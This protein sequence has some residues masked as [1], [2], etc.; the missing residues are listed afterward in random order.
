MDKPLLVHSSGDTLSITQSGEEIVIWQT[1]GDATN[2]K[3]SINSE[4]I[5]EMISKSRFMP[6]L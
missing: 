3:V 1:S 2:R 4:N 6:V 5:E